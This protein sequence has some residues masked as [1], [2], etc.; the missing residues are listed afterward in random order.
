MFKAMVTHVKECGFLNILLKVNL[1]EQT[2]M[3]RYIIFV[4]YVASDLGLHSL[5]MALLQGSRY[6]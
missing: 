5:A 2:E 4:P 1:L 3:Y 6:M